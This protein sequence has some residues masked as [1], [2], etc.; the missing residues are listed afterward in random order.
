MDL[1]STKTLAMAVAVGF[2]MIGP[3][4]GVGLVAASALEAIGRNPE[5]AGKI[6]PLMFTGIVFAEAL[7]IFALVVG[8]IVKFV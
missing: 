8:F 7:A 5:A 4:I 1:E 3:G 2:G 6:Q